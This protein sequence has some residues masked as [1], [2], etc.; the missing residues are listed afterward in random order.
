MDRLKE[1]VKREAEAKGDRH[2]PIDCQGGSLVEKDRDR[3]RWSLE[4]VAE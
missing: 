4:N 3:D 2:R 1:T